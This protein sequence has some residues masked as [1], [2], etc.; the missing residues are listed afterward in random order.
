MSQRFFHILV[1]CA[2]L[3]HVCYMTK[4]VQA[5]KVPVAIGC[6]VVVGVLTC[7]TLLPTVCDLK[8]AQMNMQCSLIQ[9]FIL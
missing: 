3:W 2:S 7:C 6:I 4:A 1:V 8:A 5:M 9:K